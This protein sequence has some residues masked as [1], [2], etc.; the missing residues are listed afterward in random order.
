MSWK[1]FLSSSIIVESLIVYLVLSWFSLAFRTW[2]GS[3]QALLAFKFSFEK[4]N[5]YSDWLS[6]VNV[7]YFSHPAFETP[8]KMFEQK[9]CKKL[10]QSILL[11]R[12]SLKQFS[13][14]YISINN[15]HSVFTHTFNKY[16]LVYM[17][18]SYTRSTTDRLRAWHGPSRVLRNNN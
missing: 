9:S 16:S 12:L 15:A 8:Q 17:Q 3:L 18:I 11:H 1:I 5:Y 2:N 7:W 14:L 4:I 13:V 6:F 10:F